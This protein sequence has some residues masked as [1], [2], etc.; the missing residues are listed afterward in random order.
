MPNNIT[1]LEIQNYKKWFKECVKYKSKAF[2]DNYDKML[3]EI[4]KSYDSIIKKNKGNLTNDLFKAFFKNTLYSLSNYLSLENQEKNK[5]SRYYEL[6]EKTAKELQKV[7]LSLSKKLDAD[8]EQGDEST[9]VTLK[10]LGIKEVTSVM[11]LQ[12]GETVPVKALKIPMLKKNLVDGDAVL[13]LTNMK[14]PIFGLFSSKNINLKEIE[15]KTSTPYLLTAIP[16]SIGFGS[17][18]NL[19]VF[20]KVNNPVGKAATF[21]ASLAGFGVAVLD[22]LVID[23]ILSAMD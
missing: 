2:P 23:D 11:G 19:C 12:I 7:V 3:K 15:P 16:L 4:K 17:T 10:K 9:V 13:V 21:G 5:K 18:A 14:G 8:V 6:R 20:F 22:S 1:A